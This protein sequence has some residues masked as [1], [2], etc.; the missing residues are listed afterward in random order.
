MKIAAACLLAIILPLS[1]VPVVSSRSGNKQSCAIAQAGDSR[2]FGDAVAVGQNYMAIGD[3]LANRIVIYQKQPRGTWSRLR[4][5]S[6]PAGSPIAKI[7]QGFGYT[8]AL[9][10]NTLVI[11]AFAQSANTTPGVATGAVYRTTIDRATPLERLDQ[12]A[13]SEITGLSVAAAHGRIAWGLNRYDQ[14]G[15]SPG[16]IEL[17]TNSQRRSITVPA[18]ESNQFGVGLALGKDLLV[19]SSFD[20]QHKVWLFDLAQDSSKKIVVNFMAS[21][22]AV[23]DRFIAAGAFQAFGTSGNKDQTLVIRQA[24]QATALIDGNGQLSLNQ[25]FLVRSHP[26]SQVGEDNQPTQTEIFDLST[27]PPQ[28]VDRQIGVSHAGLKDNFLVVRQTSNSGIK[29]CLKPLL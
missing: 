5:I 22:I 18:A 27:M 4:I 19:S 14:T 8:L 6:P 25:K 11:G 7:G 23:S 13:A 24:D 26:G 20:G 29:I 21:Q 28:L 3:R 2:L 15:R 10:Q 12:P 1:L 9:D 16:R 17:L